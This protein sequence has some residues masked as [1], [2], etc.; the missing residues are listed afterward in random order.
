M[1]EES[2]ANQEIR[3][4]GRLP[5]KRRREEEDNLG[6]GSGADQGPWSSAASATTVSPAKADAHATELQ[7]DGKALRG[8]HRE[9]RED[10]RE[11]RRLILGAL[12]SPPASYDGPYEVRS[13]P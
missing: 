3:K 8:K 4:G 12:A 13:Q 9:K 1:R 6:L 10:K 5:R 2:K 7:G 11:R